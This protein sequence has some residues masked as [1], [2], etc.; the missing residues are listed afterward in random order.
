MRA[1]VPIVL[2]TLSGC[3]RVPPL[4]NTDPSADSL[5]AEVLRALAA[6]DRELLEAVALSEPEFRHHVWQHLPAA[7]PERNVPLSYVWGDLH[8]KSEG[9]LTQGLARHG[10]RNYE[11]VTVTFTGK[12]DYG[13]YR[14]HREATF[15]VRDAVGDT[16]ALRVIG[17]MIEQD[18]AW[19]VF[20]YVVDE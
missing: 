12:T 14:V 4:A 15:A 11:L 9:M 7:R 18:G 6:K 20:S 16:S 5:A 2:L 17:S 1:F 13:P 3:A 19:K 10:G 8:Q